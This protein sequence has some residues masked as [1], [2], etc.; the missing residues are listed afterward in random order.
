M[1][2]NIKWQNEVV[3]KGYFRKELNRAITPLK[4][5]DAKLRKELHAV[6][7]RLE[8]KMDS[9]FLEFEIKMDQRF[10][11]LETYIRE[12]TD[13]VMKLADAVIRFPKQSLS[14]G[15]AIP[16]GLAQ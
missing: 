9:R 6:E 1:K 14:Y 2:K 7:Y 10:N 11:R 15:C 8:T 12:R 4:K 5:A 16:S 3:T 13:T